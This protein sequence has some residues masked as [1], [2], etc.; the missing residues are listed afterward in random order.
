M[1]HAQ[2][3]GYDVA[4]LLKGSWLTLK[5]DKEQAIIKSLTYSAAAQKLQEEH[6]NGV[7]TTYVYETQTQR[8]TEIKTERLAGHV[9]NAKVLQDLCYTYDPV[10]NVVTMTNRA[11]ATR[12][13]RNQK[14]A[15]DHRYTYDSLYQLVRA[16]GRE[17]AHSAPQ[18]TSLPAVTVPI[19]SDETAYTNY[20]RAYTYDAGG[21]LT[22][23]S[24]RTPATGNHYTIAMTVSNRSN[25]AVLSTLTETPSNVDGFFDGRGHQTLLQWG[26]TL[27]WNTR[28][29]LGGVS[30]VMHA[31]AASNNESYRYDADSQRLVKT[32]TQQSK[33]RQQTGRTVYLPGVTLHTQTIGS[34]LKETLHTLTVGE[35]SRARVRVLHWEE[36]GKP[37][38]I[39]NNQVRYRY[40]NLGGSS[41]LEIDG[42]G[43][44]ISQEEYYPYGGTAVWTARS[45]AE[46]DYKVIRYAG[47]ERDATGLYYYGYRYYQPWAGR[48]LSAD[49]GGTVDGL[50]LYRMVR[51]NPVRYADRRGLAAEDE[52]QD[53]HPASPRPEAEAGTVEP[54]AQF[55]LLPEPSLPTTQAEYA[56]LKKINFTTTLGNIAFAHMAL[57]HVNIN[58]RIRSVNKEYSNYIT[59]RV[60]GRKLAKVRKDVDTLLGENHSFDLNAIRA[61]AAY[62]AESA[63]GNCG[64]KAAVAF[65]Y[66][67]SLTAHPLDFMVTQSGTL[68]GSHA[69]VVIGRL[70][71]SS[72]KDP[73]TWGRKAVVCDPWDSKVYLASSYFSNMYFKGQLQSKYRTEGGRQAFKLLP[74]N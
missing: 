12:F 72:P 30:R 56:L 64:E 40:D 24:H 68:L 27:S 5:G 16:T 19:P 29:E 61:R 47:K 4:G 23:I 13:W 35:V 60:L 37:H 22:R 67:K 21:N 20:T 9:A 70:K 57:K 14:V 41:G 34:T 28:G 36:A 17:M 3:F 15:P 33:Y 10:G 51:N 43:K 42:N 7:V 71:D 58:L 62:S 45:H 6:G 11:H 1:G 49:P 73:T 26:Q 39:R 44:V 2:R 74:I 66:L 18:G 46:A 69:F 8:L 55:S 63:V 25:R 59:Q 54:I 53:L 48:W 65:V 31:G 32:C 52:I 50:N 38:N